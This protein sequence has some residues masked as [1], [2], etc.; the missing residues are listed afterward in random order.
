MPDKIK[1][2]IIDD[3]AIVRQVLAKIINSHP[4]MTVAGT[5]A[6]PYIARDKIKQLNPDVLTLD[7][8]MPRM[9]GHQFLRNLMRLHP[10]P[11]IMISSLA[12]KRTEAKLQALKLGA[13]DFIHKP[14]LTSTNRL[15]LFADEVCKKIKHAAEIDK[16]HLQATSTDHVT[17][18][19][20][21]PATV[22]RKNNQ[23]LA[24][25]A[26]TGGTIALHNL[27]NRLPQNT[28][29]TV[30]VQHIPGSFSGPFAKRLDALSPMK[31]KEA[32]DGENI[33]QGH[34][35]VAPG[36][37]HLTIYKD[38]EFYRC[39]LA[40]T[41]PVN[42][43]RPSVDVLFNSVAECAPKNS[44]GVILTG[45][46]KDGANG[47][48]CIKNSG[49]PTIAQDKAS[50]VVWGMPGSAVALNAADEVLPLDDIAHHICSQFSLKL[51][52]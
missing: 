22:S 24:I 44:M 48:L 18:D 7:V 29:G 30:I 39:R 15:D 3:S 2:L 13:V 34:A 43:H 9:D 1:V 37:Q 26:S 20:G 10:M 23:V 42:R 52:A 35:Y 38:G 27:M 47:L 14:P 32:E 21:Q 36:T 12:G 16:E 49:S 5:A 40:D 41:E 8:E 33:L 31:I 46:G 17:L 19:A 11:V 28:P 6:D 51:A 4:A 25:G 50:S 45:M